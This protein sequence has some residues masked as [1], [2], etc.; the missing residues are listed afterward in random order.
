MLKGMGLEVHGE[1]LTNQG[2]IDL[3]I[4]TLKVTYIMEL[5]LDSNANVALEQIKQKKY[6]EQYLH[7]EKE[8]AVLG[9]NFSSE[10][11]NIDEWKGTLFSF[12]G[13]E[14]EQFNW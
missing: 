2:R 10:E 7:K 6:F 3:V 1:K 12:S 14:L 13:N 4:E 9:V 5:K 8:V 11:R